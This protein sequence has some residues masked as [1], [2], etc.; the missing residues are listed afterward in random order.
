MPEKFNP[1]TFFTFHQTSTTMKYKFNHEAEAMPET[2]GIT[3]ER[4]DEIEN[5]IQGIVDDYSGTED[6]DTGILLESSLNKI[7]P[8]NIVE[9]A[10]IGY[11]IAKGVSAAIIG[12]IIAKGVS[13]AERNM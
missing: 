9:A 11:I 3:D 1:K 5:T 2:V 13:E 7:D 4:W 8:E 6:I 12:Y 10:I